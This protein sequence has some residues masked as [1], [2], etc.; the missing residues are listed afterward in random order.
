MTYSRGIQIEDETT[1]TIIRVAKEIA[2]KEGIEQLSVK[3]I[4]TEMK[5]SNRVFYNRFRNIEDV[6]E[7]LYEQAVNSFR[8]I[9]DLS[10][11]EQSENYYETLENL[12]VNVVRCLYQNNIHFRA[13]LLTYEA[14]KDNNRN[15][16]ITQIQD[17][18]RNGVE[19]GLLRPMDELAVARGIWCFCLGFHKEALGNSVSEQDAISSFRASFSIFISGMKM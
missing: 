14:S 3:R 8:G 9:I 17:I 6:I 13:R 7:L 12:A 15:W 10:L 2:Q 11:L 5:V 1:V 4:L 19:R 16:W 18:L